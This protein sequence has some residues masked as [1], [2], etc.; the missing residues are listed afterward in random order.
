MQ[1]HQ[2]SRYSL[3]R[4]HAHRVFA[5]KGERYFTSC[6]S[7]VVSFIALLTTKF[8]GINWTNTQAVVFMEFLSEPHCYRR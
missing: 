3:E 5:V 8:D 4:L 2:R 6:T 1:K 7:A